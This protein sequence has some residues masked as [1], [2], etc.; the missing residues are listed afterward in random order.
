MTMRR[1]EEQEQ[2]GKG[3]AWEVGLA[4]GAKGRVVLEVGWG[5]AAEVQV[6]V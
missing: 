1:L 5:L 3:L 2:E 6:G 4:Q